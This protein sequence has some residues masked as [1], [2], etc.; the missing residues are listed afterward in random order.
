MTVFDYYVKRN[1]VDMTIISI[2]ELN[3]NLQIR[4][5]TILETQVKRKVLSF[6]VIIINKRI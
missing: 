4:K 3:H 1:E 2:T 5:H 6:S